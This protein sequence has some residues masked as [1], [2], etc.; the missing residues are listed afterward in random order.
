MNNLQ[1]FFAGLSNEAS[2]IFMSFILVGL[3][4]G[5]LIGY[6]LRGAAYARLAKG[7]KILQD[8]IAQ[9]KVEIDQL[10]QNSNVLERNKNELETELQKAKD[11]RTKMAA[12]IGPVQK[13]LESSQ[14]ELE[15][16][17]TAIQ[18]YLSTIDDMHDQVMGL[19]SRNERLSDEENPELLAVEG[20]DGN[21]TKAFEVLSAQ[22]RELQ[23]SN[24]KIT[25][26]LSSLRSAG[27]VSS[28]LSYSPQASI[29]SEENVS[30]PQ[31]FIPPEV[32]P[33]QSLENKEDQD[34]LTRISGI[35]PFLQ[36]KLSE[37]NITTFQ[38]IAD[39]SSSDI[40]VL[41][42]KIGYI[43]GRIEKDDWP[44]QAKTILSE[45]E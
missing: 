31:A 1:D 8:E 38:Q 13:E 27:P 30:F 40:Q 32:K 11:D 42:Q 33:L 21:I 6:L 28:D 22:L 43:P 9:K 34:D 35:G 39:L 4:F 20:N 37:V 24:Q 7:E 44:G 19:K 26:E 29:P 18:G 10:R 3:L 15:E 2:L 25:E 14:K 36:Q 12:R 45:S 41:T 17:K 23:R 16:A 5:V